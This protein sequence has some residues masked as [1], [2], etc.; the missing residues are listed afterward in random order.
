MVEERLEDRTAV[1]HVHQQLLGRSRQRHGDVVEMGL[2]V[3]EQEDLRRTEAGD[4]AG[5]LGSDR[6]SRAGDEDP[7]IGQ[8][9]A[10]R[11]ADRC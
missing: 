10:H 2:V 1:G 6:P 9:G 3:V 7:L 4:L 5:D 8:G 11:A